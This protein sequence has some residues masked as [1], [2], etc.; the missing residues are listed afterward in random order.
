MSDL[1]RL[2]K[3]LAHTLGISRR[4]ADIAISQ[5]RV[6]VNGKRVELGLVEQPDRDTIT[7]DDRNV[8]TEKKR[9]TYWLMNKPIGYVGSRKQQDESPTIYAI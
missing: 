1:V 5:G 2:N 8:S 3:H 9:Y 4:E 7:L 6:V